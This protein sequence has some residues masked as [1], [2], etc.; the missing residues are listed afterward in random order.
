MN[1]QVVADLAGRVVDT[2]TPIGG[3]R[4]DWV[5]LVADHGR[6]WRP[7]GMDKIGVVAGR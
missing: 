3:S 7:P 4:H 5:P 2:G 1:V 6:R